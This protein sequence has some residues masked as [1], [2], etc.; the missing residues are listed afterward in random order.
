M[1]FCEKGFLQHLVVVSE[2]V[3]KQLLCISK[4]MTKR[5][6]LLPMDDFLLVEQPKQKMI[7]KSSKK[8]KYI[9]K[10]PI[11]LKKK[12]TKQTKK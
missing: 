1:L 4:V 3:A 9:K 7:K 8:A 6:Q 2:E 12:T 5:V 10:S 11:R